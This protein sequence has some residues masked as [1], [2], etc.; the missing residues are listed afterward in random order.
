MIRKLTNNELWLAEN[1]FAN[2]KQNHPGL[3]L[4]QQARIES[5][6]ENNK[7]LLREL[8]QK[9]S[10]IQRKFIVHDINGVALYADTPPGER[11]EWLYVESILN[12]KG[13]LITGDAVAAQYVIDSDKLLNEIVKVEL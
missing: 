9:M 1:D 4:L 13:E 12:A 5:F 2:L 7:K 8:H 6:Y 3:Y 10:F 11:K